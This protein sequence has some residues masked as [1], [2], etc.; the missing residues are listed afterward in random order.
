MPFRLGNKK[1]A[2]LRERVLHEG[3]PELLQFGFLVFNVLASFGIK[4]HDQ[5]F[6]G[7]CFLVFAGRVEVTCAGCR[8]QLDFF[9]SAFGRHDRVLSVTGIK[10]DRVNA[11]QPTRRRCRFCRSNAE[12]R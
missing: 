7:H 4:F 10:L 11:S 9:A 5:H 3:Q 2:I 8:F 12:L 1:P 6:L